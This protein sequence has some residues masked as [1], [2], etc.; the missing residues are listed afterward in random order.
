MR[1]YE[2]KNMPRKKH[3]QRQDNLEIGDHKMILHTDCI[4]ISTSVLQNIE[5]LG[6]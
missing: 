4:N 3:D 2:K 6:N 1:S 5:T